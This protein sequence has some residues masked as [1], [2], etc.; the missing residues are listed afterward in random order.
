MKSAVQAFMVDENGVTAIEYG[1]IAGLVGAAM[2]A[3]AIVLGDK[4][5]ATYA[6]VKDQ[7]KSLW[8]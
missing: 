5:L 6:Y 8:A 4:L 2:V 3:A 1:L 7:F